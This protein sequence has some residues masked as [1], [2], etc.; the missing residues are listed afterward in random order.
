MMK[1]MAWP[2]PL[3]K[4]WASQAGRSHHWFP[5]AI[6]MAAGRRREASR[7]L[8]NQINQNKR[9]SRS[10]PSGT[11]I[12]VLCRGIRA[13]TSSS[14]PRSTTTTCFISKL[15]CVTWSKNTWI[16]SSSCSKLTKKPTFSWDST[17]IGSW[18]GSTSWNTLL[19]F[20]SGNS[21]HPSYRFSNQRSRKL[22]YCN[23][24]FW[25][26]SFRVYRRRRKLLKSHHL[27]NLTYG[28]LKTRALRSRSPK[29]SVSRS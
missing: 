12:W 3:S 19:S 22:R 17:T 10:F 4:N 18:R 20:K 24:K 23:A 29:K 1:I 9:S 7:S 15:E 2:F 26:E 28:A 6:R 11:Q 5:K 21:T 27:S 8:Q 16:R 14:P 13:F 25:A